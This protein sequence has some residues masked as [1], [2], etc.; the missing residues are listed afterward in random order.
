MVEI[1]IK[2]TN[3]ADFDRVIENL[4]QGIGAAKNETLDQ[5]ADEIVSA[6]KAVCPVRTGTLRDSLGVIASDAD[7]RTVGSNVE[8]A[9]FVEFGTVKQRPQNFME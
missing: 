8:Y 9:P 5:A 4:I 1:S 7:S 3:K 6:S 2:F